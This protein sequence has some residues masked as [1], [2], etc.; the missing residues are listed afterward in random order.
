[1]TPATIRVQPVTPTLAAGVRALQVAPQQRDYV[2]DAAFNLAQAQTD[3]LSEAMAILA[4]DHVIGFY[5]L[6]F[7]PNAVAGRSLGAPSV[8]LRAFMLDLAQQGRGYGTRAALALC[9][10]LRRRHPQ[11][12]LLVLM[13]NCRNRAAVATYRK[14]G[15]VDTGEFH[16]GGRA[17]PQHLML[18][19][20]HD[21]GLADSG[22]GQ[23]RHG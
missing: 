18:R 14:A 6:D 9:D 21:G 1:M 13:V 16:R 11:R 5:C 12:R 7:A 4:D 10:D 3:P 19:G 8:G 20:L 22:M 17:G 2:G 23:W 15:F